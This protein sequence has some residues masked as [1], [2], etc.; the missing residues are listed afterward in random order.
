[1]EKWTTRDWNKLRNLKDGRKTSAGEH[2][3]G[4]FLNDPRM[5]II[6]Q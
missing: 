4:S 6:R 5:Y 3:R 2:V 1:M